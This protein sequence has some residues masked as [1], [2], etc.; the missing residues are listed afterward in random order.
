MGQSVLDDFG[1][2]QSSDGF[3]GLVVVVDG[4]LD[5]RLDCATHHALHGKHGHCIVC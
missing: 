3:L 4:V 5:K 1:R 2:L